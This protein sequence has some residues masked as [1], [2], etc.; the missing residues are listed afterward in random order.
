MMVLAP[1]YKLSP[2]YLN[3]FNEL[4]SPQGVMSYS[5]GEIHNKLNVANP[6]YDYVPPKLV[7]LYVTNM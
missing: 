2:Q 6:L 3:Q 5:A 1:M 7:T 4:S